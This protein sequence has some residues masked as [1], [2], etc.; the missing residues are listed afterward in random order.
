MQRIT[1]I[2]FAAIFISIVQAADS[3]NAGYFDIAVDS[4]PRTEVTGRLNP[5]ANRN[6]DEIAPQKDWSFR[7]TGG[8]GAKIFKVKS[9]WD[10]FGHLYGVIELAKGKRLKNI[11][12][13]S[14]ELA[15]LQGSEVAENLEVNIHVR[16]STRW[17]DFH[18]SVKQAFEKESR[19]WGR[20][21]VSEKQA[22]GIIQ[23]LIESNGIYPGMDYE[24]P[25]DGWINI[26]NHIGG[27]GRLLVLPGK[28][29]PDG[30]PADRRLLRKALYHAYVQLH[31]RMPVDQFSEF[32]EIVY[33]N[34]S[35]QWRYTDPL[36]GSAVFAFDEWLKDMSSE[37]RELAALASD[38]H[39]KLLHIL[40]IS[41]QA[42]ERNRQIPEDKVRFAGYW[43]DANRDHRMRTWIG[44]T[45]LMRD[46]NRPITYAAH[47]YP[48]TSGKHAG[49]SLLPGWEPKGSFYDLQT[50]V[51]T[52]IRPAYFYWDTA[53]A[54]GYFPD[55]SISHHTG[56]GNDVAL[57]AYGFSWLADKCIK[58][59]GWF[60]GTPWEIKDPFWSDT[61]DY[62]TYTYDAVVYRGGH[63]MAFSGRSHNSSAVAEFGHRYLLGD[64][65]LFA[66]NKPDSIHIA[67]ENE[68][69]KLI[70]ELN[71]GTHQRSL[72]LPFWNGTAMI[73]RR[74]AN[75]ED[76]Y[77]M[78]V[79]MSS[80]RTR[81]AE[82]FDP[83]KYSY[84]MGDGFFQTKTTGREYFDSRFDWDWHVLPGTTTEWRTD[85]LPWVKSTYDYA[86]GSNTY[87]GV[88]SDGDIGAASFNHDR[89]DDPY[90]SVVAKKSY[91]MFNTVAVMTGSGIKRVHPGQRKSIITTIDQASWT[92]DIT[93][94]LGEDSIKTVKR[95]KD[96]ALELEAKSITWFHQGSTGY[97]IWP[98]T[99]SGSIRI[100]LVT[101]SRINDTDTQRSAKS[102]V[103]HLSLNHGTN[104]LPATAEYAYAIIPNVRARSMTSV[105]AKLQNQLRIQI[106]DNDYHAVS[107]SGDSVTQA[108]FFKPASLAAENGLNISV[109][110]AA[111]V[112][113]K[114][115]GDE[116]QAVLSDPDYSKVEPSI[117]L[118]ISRK[119]KSGTYPY[120]TMGVWQQPAEAVKVSPVKAGTRLTFQLPDSTDVDRYNNRHEVYYGMPASVRIP[121]LDH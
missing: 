41:W 15:L 9:R 92:T 46:Y 40:G 72:N 16:E 112:L 90:C 36:T 108:A 83:D 82:G 25:N 105:V 115:N 100:S 71:K 6:G 42:P 55:G 19:V 87:A 4:P 58:L 102:A 81:G 89:S 24:D 45:V 57:F 117:S 32:E 107:H 43:S 33:S 64:L 39:E 8:S 28:Y 22:D 95:G 23:K 51:E 11:G 103:F 119:L 70:D 88:V 26:C 97:V 61:A 91:F 50:W 79:K 1:L 59:G 120:A 109:N 17:E 34:R 96:A 121:F 77:Y 56:H 20:V 31:G 67:N 68:I 118:T 35:H 114:D 47:W 62:L 93:Y 49:F 7:I 104:P 98:N 65:Q 99:H 44:M 37:D 73:H 5:K 12:K 94:N 86:T 18:D 13:M 74:G 2:L 53:R 85:P 69:R 111:M 76:P 30:S 110:A 66:S 84:H 38:A 113:I 106:S 116:L 80:T 101:G 3:L 27:L 63:D 29:G 75:R 14:L 48:Y 10:Q 54:S 21:D 78:S 60:A 52:N